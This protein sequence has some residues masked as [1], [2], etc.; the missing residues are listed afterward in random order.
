MGEEKLANITHVPETAWIFIWACTG[1]PDC[2]S[3]G[4][5]W[6]RNSEAT[7]SCPRSLSELGQPGL[8]AI[9]PVSHTSRQDAQSAKV[10]LDSMGL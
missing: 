10:V 1:Q 6:G 5:M 2:S 4:W 8:P 9:L 3:Q 7:L